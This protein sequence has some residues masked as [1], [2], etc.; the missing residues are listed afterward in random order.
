MNTTA[1]KSP[2]AGWKKGLIYFIVLGLSAVLIWTQLPEK[3]YP[4]DLNRV[5]QG[6]PA[7]VLIYD[8][9]T[10]GGMMTMELLSPLREEY[11]DNVEFLVASLG[12]PEGRAFAN[13]YGISSGALVFFLADATH[14]STL[15]APESTPELRRHLERTFTNNTP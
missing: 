13:H 15:R 2:L 7:V 9:N 8:V 10:A 12:L 14:S 4:T 5:G 3:P 1:P 11:G 6:K